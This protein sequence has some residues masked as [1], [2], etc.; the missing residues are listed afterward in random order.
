[1]AATEMKRILAPNLSKRLGVEMNV[2]QG[3]VNRLE[4]ENYI[5]NAGKGKR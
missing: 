5:S 1:M 3:L 2:A 4:K